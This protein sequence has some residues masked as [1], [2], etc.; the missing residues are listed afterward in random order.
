M[1]TRVVGLLGRV[2]SFDCGAQ[3]NSGFRRKEKTAGINEVEK[4]G[5]SSWG[6]GSIWLAS[7]SILSPVAGNLQRYWMMSV[8]VSGRRRHDAE[9]DDAIG[10]YG[11]AAWR[12]GRVN[13]IPFR[14][15]VLAKTG[16]RGAKE[17]DDGRWNL[18]G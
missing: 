15:H 1:R 14:G 10:R 13:R 8:I 5:Q 12:T 4:E 16:L 17:D 3:G 9:D 11:A 7:L 2:C 18:G 6:R